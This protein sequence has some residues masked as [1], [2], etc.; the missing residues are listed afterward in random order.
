[1]FSRAIH[2]AQEE[3]YFFK[4]QSLNHLIFRDSKSIHGLLHFPN[5]AEV[6]NIIDGFSANTG[7]IRHSHLQRTENSEVQAGS[8]R[9]FTQMQEVPNIIAGFHANT[10]LIKRG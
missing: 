4:K 5:I 6:S 10:V 3:K 2:V 8:M 7:G 9:F 1:M